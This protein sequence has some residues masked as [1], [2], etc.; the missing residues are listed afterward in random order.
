MNKAFLFISVL[1]VGVFFSCKPA[2]VASTKK[3]DGETKSTKINTDLQPV[4]H[5]GKIDPE[6]ETTRP[7]KQSL[8]N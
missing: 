3:V 8:P 7:H 4:K 1:I 6:N 5:S 2:E